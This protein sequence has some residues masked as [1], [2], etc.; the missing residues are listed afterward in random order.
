MA[1][2]EEPEAAFMDVM[3]GSVKIVMRECQ[4]PPQQDPPQFSSCFCR[5][6]SGCPRFV[7]YTVYHEENASYKVFHIK[8]PENRRSF[9]FRGAHLIIRSLLLH[10]HRGLQFLSLDIRRCLLITVEIPKEVPFPP[11]MNAGL[12]VTSVMDSL[13][14]HPLP[15]VHPLWSGSRIHAQLHG[16]GVCRP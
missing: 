1:A 14:V 6:L 3:A 10:L 9:G 5:N 16:R 13:S 12:W 4:D 8:T 11:V 7:A 2:R 15:P